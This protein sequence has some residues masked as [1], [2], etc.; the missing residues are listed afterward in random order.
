LPPARQFG[1]PVV[2]V[3]NASTDGTIFPAEATVLRNEANR[4]FAAA[5]NQGVR[6]HTAPLTLLLNAGRPPAH[7]DC[8]PLRHLRR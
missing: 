3:D 7:R 1:I 2:V 4:G 8:P 6:A 5:V